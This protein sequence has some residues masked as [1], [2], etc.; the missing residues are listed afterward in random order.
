MTPTARPRVLAVLASA[1]RRLTQRRPRYGRAGHGGVILVVFMGNFAFALGAITAVHAADG[2]AQ[3]SLP[4]DVGSIS[5]NGGPHNWVGCTIT[6]GVLQ[7]DC[8]LNQPWNSLDWAPANGR[9]YASHSGIAHI[10]MT[11]WRTGAIGA[12]CESTTTMAPAT[13]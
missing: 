3:L 13:R 10:Y 11:A 2:T 8:L 5:L 12:S 9:V 4:S 1:I 7:P 6:N